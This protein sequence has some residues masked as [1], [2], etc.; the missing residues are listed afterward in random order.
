MFFALEKG[1]DLKIIRRKDMPYEW[2]KHVDEGLAPPK[3][4][5]SSENPLD[6]KEVVWMSTRF[7]STL[8]SIRYILAERLAVK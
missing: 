5:D 3:M 7:C 8:F 6:I 2:D 4:C 1:A